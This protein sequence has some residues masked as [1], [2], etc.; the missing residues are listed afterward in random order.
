M[1]PFRPE[2]GAYG[3]GRTH[4]HHHGGATDDPD[5]RGHED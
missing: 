4:G 3:H 1:A 5:H 2:G